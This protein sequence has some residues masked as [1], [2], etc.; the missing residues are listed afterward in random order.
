MLY[1]H[2][3]VQFHSTK[4][5]NLAMVL[6]LFCMCC[7]SKCIKYILF[8]VYSAVS[9]T[10]WWLRSLPKCKPPS[11]SSLYHKSQCWK[12]SENFFSL[13]CSPPV[14]LSLLSFCIISLH[15]TSTSCLS[16]ALCRSLMA[17]HHLVETA[18]LKWSHSGDV[19]GNRLFSCFSYSLIAPQ[20]SL[21]RVS[22]HSS[23]SALP[24]QP[25]QSVILMH[26][27]A[28]SAT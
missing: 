21:I 15:L 4:L 6:R 19:D 27:A 7:L 18:L 25:F 12:A 14:C 5:K 2:L 17:C 3:L 11:S 23:S 26:M 9:K 16:T 13:C 22:K 20:S 1:K 10:E 28:G 24:I 8:S